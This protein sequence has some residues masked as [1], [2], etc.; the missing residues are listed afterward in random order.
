MPTPTTRSRDHKRRQ[1]KSS[2]Q[3]CP[4]PGRQTAE[5]RPTG[6]EWHDPD[7]RGRPGGGGGAGREPPVPR[8]GRKA[9]LLRANP[10]RCLSKQPKPEAEAGRESRQQEPQRV[11]H[12]MSPHAAQAP[13]HKES[14]SSEVRLPHEIPKGGTT[15]EHVAGGIPQVTQRRALKHQMQLIARAHMT[16]GTEPRLARNIGR[17]ASARAHITG[18]PVTAGTEAQEI[19]QDSEGHRQA[20]HRPAGARQGKEPA[21]VGTQPGPHPRRKAREGR[22]ARPARRRRRLLKRRHRPR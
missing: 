10:A 8:Q 13:M 6:V 16:K 12:G 18:Q 17:P 7:G 20:Q 14:N 15:S 3:T 5:T 9:R 11:S 19:A 21:A 2:Q 4:T 1:R 22:N